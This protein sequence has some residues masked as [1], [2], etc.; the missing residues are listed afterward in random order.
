MVYAV[1]DC[2]LKEYASALEEKFRVSI[3]TQRISQIFK[4]E[5]ISR[6]KVV[7]PRHLSSFQDSRRSQG[8]RSCFTGSVDP[9]AKPVQS[10]TTCLP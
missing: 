3:T 2:L 10:R 8:A 9:K 5:G 1:P 4:E 7:A 6:K